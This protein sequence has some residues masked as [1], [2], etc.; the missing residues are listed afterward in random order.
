MAGNL[1]RRLLITLATLVGAVLLA[2]AAITG[3]SRRTL[4][5][6]FDVKPAEVAIPTD[7][8]SIERG[9]HLATAIAKCTDCHGEDLGGVAMEMG[10]MGTFP[11][12]NLTTGRG[13][14][15][16]S[17]ADWVRAIHHGVGSDGRALV[18]M[19]SQPYSALSA[20]DLGAII[21]WAKSMPPVDRELPPLDVGPIGRVLIATNPGRLVPSTVIDHS[22]PFATEIPAGPTSEYGKY[23][24]VV[25]GCTYCHGDN[26]AGGIKEGPP[27]TPA[28]SNLRPDGDIKGWSESDFTTALRTGKRPD[29]TSLNPFMPWQ[30]TRKMTDEEIAAT[31]AYL[32][33]LK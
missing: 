16:R 28:S 21:A 11:A 8:A 18:F 14:S 31:W 24:T 6:H 30:A 5:R 15:A 7:S 12:K 19:P 20:A 27:G 25:G 17:D 9:H 23:L 29:G 2:A 1:K 32:R 4:N 22:A 13:G 10:P 3:M 26:L 33:S